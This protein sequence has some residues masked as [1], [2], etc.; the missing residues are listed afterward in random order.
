MERFR[1]IELE[2]TK[3][4]NTY[5]KKLPIESDNSTPVIVTTDNQTGG[6]G[7]RGNSWES[8]PGAN[9]TFS[10]VLYPRWMAP[11]RQFELSMLVSI[12]IIY[13]LRPYT[14]T[15]QWL[16]IKWPNDIYFGDR[17]L[18]GIL[19]ENS[20]GKSCIERSIIG[21]GLNVNQKEFHSDA[22]N[23]V[24]LCEITGA[25]VDRRELLDKVTESI[26]DMVESYE[27][28][29]EPDELSFL[30]NNLLWRNDEGFH[31][32]ERPDGT[33]FEAMLSGVDTD[34]RLRLRDT[35]GKTHTFLFKEV[36][37]VL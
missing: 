15:P 34:G 6:R 1:T 32:W 25:D 18:A 16:K 35:D 29:P 8:E 22:P 14:D 26:L 2:S 9:L 23:P 19:I 10:L 11:A 7:Q 3:S 4:T 37:A 24:S 17:K 20:L 21:I 12:G 31:K 33:V 27:S 28:D 30:Y 36:A 13:A 5:A